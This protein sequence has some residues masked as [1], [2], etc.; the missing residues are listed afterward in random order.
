MQ[1]RLSHLAVIAALFV[2]S[3]LATI[4]PVTYAQTIASGHTVTFHDVTMTVPGDGW[5]RDGKASNNDRL[6]L[7][8]TEPL[9]EF[10]VSIAEYSPSVPLSANEIADAYF[11]LRAQP[12]SNGWTLTAFKSGTRMIGG[13]S[14]PLQT[15]HG[16]S[17]QAVGVLDEA[18]LMYFPSD[19]DV[20]GRFYV[21]V[22]SDY[23]SPSA[24][25]R[26]LDLL[27]ALVASASLTPIGTVLSS[28]DFLDPD[29]GE[30]RGV[31]GNNAT[32][33]RRQDGELVLQD[34]EGR[35]YQ[36]W[37][38]GVYANSSV[39]VDVYVGSE[40]YGQLPILFC[41]RDAES[42]RSSYE[43]A[44]DPI[45]GRY[46]IAKII[47]GERT[48]LIPWRSSDAIQTGTQSNRVELI[49]RNTTIGVAVNDT[50]VDQVQDTALF[51]GRTGIGLNRIG[52][53]E[54]L[55]EIHFTSFMVYQQ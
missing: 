28:D 6:R 42:P 10:A 18:L 16:T 3:S 22:W 24:K 36:A 1:F 43:L 44:I 38:G 20:R 47:K 54:V 41:R 34:V 53:T 31:K 48:P 27:D 9:H 21:F 39:A 7:T 13:V 49:C 2:V 52:G 33:V 50:L 8:R 26:D 11:K 25:P 37:T 55:P 23:H 5:N 51:T 29:N 32:I 45:R 30:L 17:D 4:A 40:D 19:Y 14:Y 12:S 35:N 46:Q 15:N